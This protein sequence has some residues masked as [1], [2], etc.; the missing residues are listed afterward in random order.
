MA[1]RVNRAQGESEVVA[2]SSDRSHDQSAG[3][4]TGQ[5]ASGLRSKVG[6]RG[7]I[8]LPAP[9]RRR[10]G[11]EEGSTVIAEAREEGILLRPASPRIEDYTPERKA[12][13]LLSNTLDREDY[14]D[15]VRVVRSMGLDPDKIPHYK[16]SG[17]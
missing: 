3:T 17:V 11:I 10:F 1:K 9:L 7:A 12:E 8:V 6:K 15:A 13:F 2:R 5:A 14:Q 16:P 4:S